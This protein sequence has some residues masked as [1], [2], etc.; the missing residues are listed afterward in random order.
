MDNLR[1][2]SQRAQQPP[3]QRRSAWGFFSKTGIVGALRYVLEFL[4]WTVVLIVFSLLFYLYVVPLV[5]R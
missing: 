1:V 5:N 2:R 3:A 4:F